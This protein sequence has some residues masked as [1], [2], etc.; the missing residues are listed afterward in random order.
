MPGL[1]YGIIESSIKP[2]IFT[3]RNTRG[4]IEDH[5]GNIIL[6]NLLTSVY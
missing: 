4:S 3:S 2:L 6:D 5:L 1:F